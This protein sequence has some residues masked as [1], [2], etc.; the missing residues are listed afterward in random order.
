MR[1]FASESAS[2]LSKTR[3][4]TGQMVLVNNLTLRPLD[5][6]QFAALLNPVPVEKLRAILKQPSLGKTLGKT[7]FAGFRPTTLRKDRAVGCFERA[8]RQMNGVEPATSLIKAWM[9]A[10]P[11]IAAVSRETLG[12]DNPFDAGVT[13]QFLERLQIVVDEGC[14]EAIRALLGPSA[15]A[16]PDPG[17]MDQGQSGPGAGKDSR[18]QAQPPLTE[19]TGPDSRADRP[20]SSQMLAPDEPMA[21]VDQEP[22]TFVAAANRSDMRSHLSAVGS[23]TPNS[24]PIRLQPIQMSA[25]STGEP[26]TAAPYEKHEIPQTFSNVLTRDVWA[27]NHSAV[28]LLLGQ[29]FDRLEHLPDHD[30]R[31][32]VEGPDWTGYAESAAKRAERESQ[33][34]ED[35]LDAQSY[36][37]AAG[38]IAKANSG[39][40]AGRHL[41]GILRA[42]LQASGFSVSAESLPSD[43]VNEALNSQSGPAH[44]AAIRSLLVASRSID[45]AYYVANL[46]N[47]ALTALEERL[48]QVL[49]RIKGDF[50]KAKGAQQVYGAA[51]RAYSHAIETLRKN[52]DSLAANPTISSV[53]QQRPRILESLNLTTPFTWPAEQVVIDQIRTIMGKPLTEYLQGGDAGEAKYQGLQVGIAAV[54]TS[55]QSTPS[56]LGGCVLTPLGLSL[57][58]SL[59]Q[60]Y[61]GVLLAR[62]AVLSVRLVKPVASIDGGDCW[63]FEFEV[64]NEGTSAASD[65]QLEVQVAVGDVKLSTESLAFGRLGPAARETRRCKVVCARET[66]ALTLTYQLSFSDRGRRQDQTDVLTVARPRQLDWS[67]L[68]LAASPYITRR[69]IDK[70]DKLKGRMDQLGTLRR[71]YRDRASFQV[72]GQKRVGKTSLVRVFLSE[73]AA[74]P[75]AVP[76]YVARGD[77]TLESADLGQLGWEL[78]SWTIEKFREVRAGLDDFSVPDVQEFRSGFNRT[79]V[80]FVKDVRRKSGSVPV[81]ALDDF[82]E[83]PTPLFTGDLG[84]SLFLAFRALIDDGIP[85]YFIGSERLPSIILEQGQRLNQV[86][87]MMVDYLDHEAM[88]ALVKEPVLGILEYS[89]EAILEI[90]R[91]SARNP[92]FATL[93]CGAIWGHAV[94][95][96][97]YWLAARDIKRTID[98][99]SEEN[100]IGSYQHFWADSPLTATNERELQR[101]NAFY[102]VSA[103]SSLQDDAFV[104]VDRNTLVKNTELEVEVAEEQAQSL[105]TRQVLELHPVEHQLIRFRVPLLSQWL[106]RYGF[107]LRDSEAPRVSSADAPTYGVDF[108]ELVSIAEGLSYRGHPITTDEIRLWLNQFGDA[109]NQ[110]LMLPL[111]R[112]VRKY[113]LFNL[114]AFS[115]AQVQLHRLIG[116]LSGEQGFPQ[117]VG[118]GRISNWYVTHSDVSGKSGSAM[119]KAYRSQNKIPENH[120][121][122]PEKAIGGLSTEHTGPAVLVCIDDFVGSGHSAVEGLERNILPVLKKNLG[123][124]A[125]R[126]LLVYAAV[127][128]FE[129]GLDFI[130]SKLGELCKVVCL[131]R[132]TAS[133]RAFHPGNG[134][135]D[136]PEQQTR[137]RALALGIGSA[138]EPKHSLGWE[139]GEALIV[140][141]D[142]V[143]NNSLPILCKDGSRYNG[144][145]WRPLFPRS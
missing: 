101:T 106:K 32:R 122:S 39:D 133:D 111:L 98:E 117:L 100:D 22:G 89:D 145:P 12:R 60:H 53:T 43:M 9:E 44:H 128:G 23:T 93:V 99:L 76:V 87:P 57:A 1:Q 132:L 96:H 30:S 124:W 80:K 107:R 35:W 118:K 126:V 97:D 3:P 112:G 90:E 129:D 115:V 67:S 31:A 45:D 66:E 47:A 55:L 56:F 18:V 69:S 140:F 16:A 13:D 21:A 6:K 51:A 104:W 109:E 131:R 68:A 20:H 25:Q 27:W 2:P 61:E 36:W 15:L 28:E 116:S 79:F 37:L 63:S 5:S 29:R 41:A 73:L 24:R 137:A 19:A 88:N 4:I 114:D 74:L 49:P 108:V 52:I 7:Y 141:P 82:D 72:T 54:L 139:N 34:E 33:S 26:H 127:A 86:R 75:D 17:T 105:L 77:L 81:F 120:C 59:R 142:N 135:F 123:D 91:W 14:L 138:L 83:L 64:D 65:C 70:P 8:V 113:E 125:E 58:E 130:E 143:P 38:Q 134:L 144:K 42:G 50:A 10:L 62:F 40:D 102:L 46:S 103:L 119:V 121:G 95:H 92:Y 78:A 110:N 136:S 94:N 85:F 48:R 11:S 84:S 71:G